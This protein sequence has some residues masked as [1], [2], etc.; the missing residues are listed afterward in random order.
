MFTHWPSGQHHANSLIDPSKSRLLSSNTSVSGETVTP[1]VDAVSK[2]TTSEEVVDSTTKKPS[3]TADESSDPNKDLKVQ[4]KLLE[5]VPLLEETLGRTKALKF[6][7][8]QTNKDLTKVGAKALS[9]EKATLIKSL[10]R[11]RSNVSFVIA[12]LAQNRLAHKELKRLRVL[13]EQIMSL[14]KKLESIGSL[15]NKAIDLSK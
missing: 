12:Q 11:T 9:I 5:L 4:G 6:A 7:K 2:D 10:K 14:N 8:S 13:H 15:I 3:V 1:P